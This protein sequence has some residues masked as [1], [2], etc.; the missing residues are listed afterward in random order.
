MNRLTIEK[1]KFMDDIE[2]AR[3]RPK[4]II[5]CLIVIAIYFAYNIVASILGSVF[6]VMQAMTDTTFLTGSFTEMM[7][8]VYNVVLSEQFILIMLY[9]MAILIGFVIIQ[10]RA[11]ERRKL[12][13][14]GMI[15]KGSV[16]QYLLGI[17]FG[18]L[19]LFVIMLPTLLSEI[20]YIDYKGFSN[21]V[22]LF[23][24]AFMIQS[25]GEELLFRGYLL[26]AMTRRIGV[27][28]AAIASSGLFAAFH[29]LNPDMSAVVFV[30]IFLLGL[31]FCFYM[32]RTGNIWGVCGM[33]F[34]W[35]FFQGTFSPVNAS[36]AVVDYRIFEFERVSF[37]PVTGNFWGSPDELIVV[38]ILLAA[39]AIVLFV[40]KGRIA[41]RKPGSD[42]VEF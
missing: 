2:Q 31:F 26:S 27:T 20:G 33:H 6:V 13:T 37:E 19:I 39:I 22:L 9:S 41:V 14:I 7:E 10:T 40:G 35:N 8:W 34:A 3:F 36:G 42:E 30:E 23:L 1:P 38:G 17:A 18:V 21:I 15:A 4:V 11:I 29:L 32:V 25:A 28:W 12:R 24:F 5:A 16:K